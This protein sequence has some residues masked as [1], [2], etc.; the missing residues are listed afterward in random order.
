MINNGL[1]IVTMVKSIANLWVTIAS[2]F[3]HGKKTWWFMAGHLLYFFGYKME[4]FPSKTNPKNLDPSYK[5]V[6]DLCDC[7]GKVKLLL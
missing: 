3:D 2:N 1:V 5:A 4:F 6:L 7:L